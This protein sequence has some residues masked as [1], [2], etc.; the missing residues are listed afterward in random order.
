VCVCVCVCC[1]VYSVGLRVESFRIG[2][3]HWHANDGMLL[4]QKPLLHNFP[5]T[6]IKENPPPVGVSFSES[7]I[8]LN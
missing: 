5:R 1:K 2:M 7:L 3:L 4:T 8:E 6:L